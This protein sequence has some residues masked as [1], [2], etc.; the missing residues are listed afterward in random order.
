[1]VSLLRLFYLI[2]FFSVGLSTYLSAAPFSFQVNNKNFS[3]DIPDTYC[4]PETGSDLAL[5]FDSISQALL[6][7]NMSKNMLH[8]YE[9]EPDDPD[10]SSFIWLR[11]FDKKLPNT[12]SASEIK[13]MLTEAL[14][15]SADEILSAEKVT[16]VLSKIKSQTGEGIELTNV[17]LIQ[18]TEFLTTGTIK[19]TELDGEIFK[20]YILCSYIFFR[21][22][23]MFLYLSF[24]LDQ[25]EDRFKTSL[26]SLTQISRSVQLN[27]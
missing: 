19:V 5:Y 2:L 4:Q 20:E 13:A 1:M 12:L 14:K 18:D 17:I 22:Q 8:L 23:M 9:C 21:G 7:S 25:L 16:E 15:K 10:F 26:N 27:L 11:K 3:I 6:A 24:S